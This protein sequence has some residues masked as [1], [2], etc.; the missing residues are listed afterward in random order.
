MTNDF[1]S[2]RVNLLIVPIVFLG[3]PVLIW[4]WWDSLAWFVRGV[5]VGL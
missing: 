1:I 5:M 2:R 4:F 3:T